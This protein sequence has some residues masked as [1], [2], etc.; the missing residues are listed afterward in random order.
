MPSQAEIKPPATPCVVRRA[1]ADDAAAIES[2]YGELVLDSLMH[3]LP[4]QVA[5]LAES[6]TSFLLVAD[7]RGVVCG[8]VLLT[9]C[10][11]AM[12]RRQPFGVI[13]N[14]VV[15]QAKRGTG[16][17]RRL[18]AHVEHLAVTYHCTKL[19]LLSSTSREAAHSFF[20]RCGFAS[21]TKHG[22]VKY[23]RQFAVPDATTKIHDD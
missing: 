17:G 19:M 13:E 8:T 18:L 15:A 21:E 14:I 1:L 20:Q 3:V 2:L 9:I 11:D 12:Y 4:E 6:K 7:S 10:P 23:R 5:A 16:I 22:F